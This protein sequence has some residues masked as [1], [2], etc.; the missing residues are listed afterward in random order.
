MCIPFVVCHMP[1]VEVLKLMIYSSS[2][3]V[4]WDQRAIAYPLFHNPKTAVMYWSDPK[5]YNK[6][7]SLSH[8][9]DLGFRGLWTGYGNSLLTKQIAYNDP[10]ALQPLLQCAGH[11]SCGVFWVL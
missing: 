6:L 2:Q 10:P 7:V 9:Q 3:S 4:L 11:D 5:S 1:H 8:S